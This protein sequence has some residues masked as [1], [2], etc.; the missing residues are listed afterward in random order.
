M[1]FVVIAKVVMAYIATAHVVMAYIGMGMTHVVLV[2]KVTAYIGMADM[3][4]V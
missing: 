4:M 3:V 2:C 1:V